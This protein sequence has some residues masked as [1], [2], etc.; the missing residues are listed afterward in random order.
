[1]SLRQG[2]N[3]HVA[4]INLQQKLLQ[5]TLQTLENRHMCIENFLITHKHKKLNCRHT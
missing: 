2:F 1:M 3:F 4:V 5:R